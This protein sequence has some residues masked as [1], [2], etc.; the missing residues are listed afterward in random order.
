MNQETEFLAEYFRWSSATSI[1]FSADGKHSIQFSDNLPL[2]LHFYHFSVNQRL[3]PNY[4]DYLEIDYVYKGNGKLYVESKEYNLSEGDV[5]IVGNTEFHRVETHYPQIMKVIG[6][7]FMPEL[8]YQVGGSMLDFE[9]LRPFY[10]HNSEF[11][12]KISPD[13]FLNREVFSLLKKLHSEITGRKEYYNLAVKSYLMEILS[14]IAR[15]YQDFTSDLTLYNQ[16]QHD[17]VRLR[18]AFSFLQHHYNDKISLKDVADIVF[19]STSYFCKFFRKVTGSTLMNY[20]YRLRIDKAKEFILRGDMSITEIAYEVGFENHSY[21]NR[22][23]RRFTKLSPKEFRR[24]VLRSDE[25][26]TSTGASTP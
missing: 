9:Y 10:I 22:I 19:M 23:F 3:I 15:Y 1:K 25:S 11:F 21:F 24:G 16:K 2:A 17:I 5:F 14:H 6:L 20:I 13:G 18:N 7:F 12:H 8:V 4:H 26:R